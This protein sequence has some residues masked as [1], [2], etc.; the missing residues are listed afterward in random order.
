MH[1]QPPYSLF[2]KTTFILIVIILVCKI[3]LFRI[4]SLL[5]SRQVLFPRFG[6]AESEMIFKEKRNCHFHLLKARG[7]KIVWKNADICL[8]QSSKEKCVSLVTFFC[9]QGFEGQYRNYA[10]K[11]FCKPPLSFKKLPQLGCHCLTLLSLHF[12]SN[13]NIG[14]ISIA[15]LK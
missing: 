12:H 11:A 8:N 1:T 2:R 4:F 3:Q 15:F 10:R 6:G 9:K 7:V 13:R 14:E 5:H